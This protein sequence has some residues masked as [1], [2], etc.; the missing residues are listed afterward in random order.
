[1]A[2]ERATLDFLLS[3]DVPGA[4]ALRTQV[5]SARATAYCGCGCPSIALEVDRHHAQEAVS[6][7]RPAAQTHNDPEDAEATRWLTLWADDGWLSYLE[8]SWISEEAP[9]EFPSPQLLKSFFPPGS[10]LGDTGRPR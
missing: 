3:T 5:R 9:K 10:R 7:T 4:E 6:V 8:I 2:R 1:M